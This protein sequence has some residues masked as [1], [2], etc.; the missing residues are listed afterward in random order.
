MTRENAAAEEGRA[1]LIHTHT[2]IHTKTHKHE[3]NI[4]LSG[5]KKIKRSSTVITPHVNTKGSN[6]NNAK[7]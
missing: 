7:L 3:G 5:V 4:G 1:R 2:H 6:V